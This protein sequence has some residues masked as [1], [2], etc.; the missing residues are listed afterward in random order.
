MT[1]FL[2]GPIIFVR[3]NQVGKNLEEFSFI[4]SINFGKSLE[5]NQ[6]IIKIT[7]IEE[8]KSMN[9]MTHTDFHHC[10]EISKIPIALTPLRTRIRHPNSV[11]V[12]FF[13]CHTSH[14]DTFP[15]VTV[16]F[17]VC[18]SS[19]LDTFQTVIVVCISC[20]AQ[21]STHSTAE[22]SSSSPPLPPQ[23]TRERT[24][25][26]D[27][28]AAVAAHEHCACAKVVLTIFR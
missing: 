3:N 8:K 11:M 13:V 28:S 18:H 10:F 21:N 7:K 5:K 4:N 27:L 15:S 16:V 19:D 24:G 12:V 25:R 26:N 20:H 9:L 17:F 23:T 22:W 2:F 6:Q 1:K 14:L